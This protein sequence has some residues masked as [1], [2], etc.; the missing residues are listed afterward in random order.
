MRFNSRGALALAIAT[1]LGWGP[2]AFAQTTNGG[3]AAT[4]PPGAVPQVTQPAQ[5]GDVN[6]KGVG[7]GAGTVVGN[8]LYVPAKLVY[9]ILGGV[10][11]G[12]GYVLT[13]GNQQVSN[14]I[15]RSSL[16]GDY[17]LTPN[18]ITGKE[19]IH[20]SGPTQTAQSSATTGG[21]PNGNGIA[22]A[23]G[24]SAP[25]QTSAPLSTAPSSAPA[26]AS[27]PRPI[28]KGAGPVN[29]PA[30]RPAAPSSSDNGIE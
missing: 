23:T 22:L 3:N 29:A 1:L 24:S 21:D 17:V 10:A 20:F 8:V 30:A 18:M 25:A 27:A 2:A 16:G 28:D 15:W 5:G 19:P 9:G 4:T 14:T 26:A 7:V 11:G 6:W 12:A 13:G